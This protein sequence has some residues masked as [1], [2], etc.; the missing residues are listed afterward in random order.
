MHC[1]PNTIQQASGCDEPVALVGH[2]LSTKQNNQP[3]QCVT[4][5]EYL[6]LC[7]N[8]IHS[9]RRRDYY[10]YVFISWINFVCLLLESADHLKTVLI[11]LS[12]KP[13]VNTCKKALEFYNINSELTRSDLVLEGN[14]Q[15]LGNSLFFNK[16][17]P[18][19]HFPSVSSFSSAKE[20]KGESEENEVGLED[21]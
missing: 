11:S 7:A 16:A 15:H 14:F 3:I 10:M 12:E 8:R 17:V 5:I 20:D 19:R 4:R 13:F 6:Y 2:D 21:C 9:I 18:T 1:E